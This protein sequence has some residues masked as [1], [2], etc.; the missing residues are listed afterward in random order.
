MLDKKGKNVCTMDLTGIGTSICDHFVICNADSTPNVLAI[1]DNVED[2][3]I[4]KCK[5]KV[6]RQQGRE[7]AFW[8]IM[9]YGNIVVHIF[10]TEYREFYRLEDLWADADV[11]HFVDED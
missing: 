1:A 11:K 7:N 4:V 10:Q 8:I 5:T 2:E 9:D 3:M 6:V